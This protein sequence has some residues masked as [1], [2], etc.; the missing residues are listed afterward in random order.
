MTIRWK[1]PRIWPGERCF[2]IGGGESVLRQ[3]LS[4]IK[5]RIIVVKHAALLRP[6]ADCLFIAKKRWEYD[7]K[8]I[9]DKF[10][11]LIVRRGIDP[12]LPPHIKQVSRMKVDETTG[13]PG[14]SEDPTHVAGLDAGASAINLAYHFGVSEM[15]LLGF[16]MKGGH[17]YKDHPNKIISQTHFKR[18]TRNHVQIG[19]ALRQKGIRV[20]NASPITTLTC[21]E[22]TD[23]DQIV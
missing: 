3:D 9:L 19:E 18:H 23:Y 7:Y 11:G 6:D 21:Y 2:I 1:V 10:K 4:K 14:L 20:L 17:H 12:K 15:I 16:D 8:W 5:D 22:R 13:L